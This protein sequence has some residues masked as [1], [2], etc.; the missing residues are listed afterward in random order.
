[1]RDADKSHS[2]ETAEALEEKPCPLLKGVSECKDDIDDIFE[3][4]GL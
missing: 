1:M 2:Q 4:I 3:A